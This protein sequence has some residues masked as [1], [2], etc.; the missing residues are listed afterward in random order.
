MPL[1]RRTWAPCGCTPVLK[2]KGRHREK[3]STI[4]ALTISPKK[5]HLGLYCTSLLNE[6]IDHT[7]VAWFLRQLLRHL[8]GPIILVWDRGS[9]HHGPE[10]RKVLE[11]N[12][13]LTIESFPAY[14]PDLNPV[15]YLWGHLKW[16]RLNNFAPSDVRELLEQ[17]HEEIR[18]II[19]DQQRLRSFI[20][21][22][23]LHWLS[24]HQ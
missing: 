15:E 11:D 1:R 24:D 3:V 14:A 20:E 7:V 10:I 4:A 22:S 13:R 18:N 5:Q 6:S 23:G 2:H 12:P 8:R 9:T 19:P 16:N 21:A 17:L